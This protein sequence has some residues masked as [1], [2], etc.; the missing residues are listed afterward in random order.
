[1]KK[2][3]T[4]VTLLLVMV[5]HVQAELKE[6]TVNNIDL[7]AGFIE[8]DYIQYPIQKNKIILKSGE[9]KLKLSLLKKGNKINFFAD[10][11]GITEIKL[12]TPYV[13]NR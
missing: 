2:V 3:I 9:H 5:N 13:F 4:I 1:M 10:D 8:I 7:E 11:Q 12:K 6:G